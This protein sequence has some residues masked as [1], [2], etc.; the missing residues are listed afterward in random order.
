M[1]RRVRLETHWPIRYTA[2]SFSDTRLKI[3]CSLIEKGKNENNLGISLIS[4]LTFVRVSRKTI[5]GLFRL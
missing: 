2:G 4:A 1:G 5:Y 3:M